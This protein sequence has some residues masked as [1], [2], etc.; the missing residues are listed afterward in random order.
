[1]KEIYFIRHGQTDWNKKGLGQGQEA[2]IPLNDEGREQVRKSALYLKK[3][4]IVDKNFDC[5]MAS[6]MKRTKESAEIIKNVIGC[7]NDIEYLDILKERKHGKLSGADKVNPLM[8]KIN[9]FEKKMLSDDPIDKIIKMDKLKEVENE[10]FNVGFENNAT[11][12]K[13]L[14]PFIDILIKSQCKKILVVGHGGALLSLIRTLFKII[15]VPEGN[16]DNGNNCWISYIVFKNNEFKLLSPPNTEHLGL[17]LD[18]DSIQN[19]FSSKKEFITINK[20]SL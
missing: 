9:E 3:Y 5:I 8:V 2:D 1:M 20:T 10:K 4:R 13:R 6:P 12:E 14:M 7:K 15:K 11:L 19:R 17:K 16:F 18:S